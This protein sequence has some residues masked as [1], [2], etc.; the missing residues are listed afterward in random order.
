M[1]D[2]K[3]T[4]SNDC[5]IND[6]TKDPSIDYKARINAITSQ[7]NEVIDLMERVRD[8]MDGRTNELGE[9]VYDEDFDG[10]RMLL[11][12]LILKKRALGI[13]RAKELL[14][15]RDKEF[16]EKTM[17]DLEF[18]NQYFARGYLDL[19]D[20]GRFD[21]SDAELMCIE[22]LCELKFEHILIGKSVEMFGSEGA[23]EYFQDEI[24][25]TRYKIREYIHDAALNGSIKLSV[26]H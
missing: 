8:Y 26:K 19:E 21:I 4:E 22:Y 24:H 9:Y 12:G 2:A 18:I 6:G 16:Q 23:A 25:E 13:E 1:A 17:E 14:W 15:V 3:I 7:L 5:T 20:K 11:D 10:H